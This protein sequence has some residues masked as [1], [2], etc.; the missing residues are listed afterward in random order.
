[1]YRGV[2]LILAFV[3]TTP[4]AAKAESVQQILRQYGMLGTF[5]DDCSQPASKNNFYTVYAPMPNGNVRRTY[6]NG[7]N[8]IYNQY[9]LEH[10]NRI[11]SDQLFYQQKGSAGRISIVLIV[12]G[13]RYHVL[14]SQ[15]ENGKAY[16]QDGKFT[17]NTSS[18][19]QESP[20]QTK[21][22]D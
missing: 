2:L 17:S 15:N 11:S 20:W 7:P 18:P 5:A 19:G 8:K 9:V 16:V 13:N 22:H 1:M 10:V 3:L 4:L 12:A 6:Y 21:C 14:S